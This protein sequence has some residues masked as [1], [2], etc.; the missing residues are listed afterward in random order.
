MDAL[1]LCLAI[2]P[3]LAIMAAF[4][5]GAFWKTA[6]QIVTIPPGLIMAAV[7]VSVALS[8]LIFGTRY[9]L[10]ENGVFVQ[11]AVLFRMTIPYR[12][13]TSVKTA[14]SVQASAA[15]SQRRIRI[16]WR[17]P[18]VPW[19]RTCDISPRDEE[20]FLSLL[21]HRVPPEAW[22]FPAQK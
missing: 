21:K 6:G 22:D 7:V 20:R 14:S 1:Y 10:R 5:M 17:D 2:V 15:L 12:D 19:G 9:S 4:G 3:V 16:S 11:F 13:I 8:V 18:S